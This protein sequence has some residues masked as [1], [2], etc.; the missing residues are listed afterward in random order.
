MSYALHFVMWSVL[1]WVSGN[2]DN[3]ENV[4]FY[5]RW[6]DPIG[7]PRTTKYIYLFFYKLKAISKSLI[8]F[9]YQKDWTIDNFLLSIVG[10]IL[11]FWG[12]LSPNVF[13]DMNSFVS[14]CAVDLYMYIDDVWLFK[15]IG[16]VLCFYRFQLHFFPI[17]MVVVWWYK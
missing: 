10:F 17:D 16:R 11:R 15:S 12:V 7:T 5:K 14:S 6:L 13:H 2:P 4:Y 9:Y 1:Y 3:L 8:R